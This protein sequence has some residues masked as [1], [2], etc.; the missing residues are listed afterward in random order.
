MKI[1]KVAVFSTCLRFGGGER[2]GVNI[3]NSLAADPAMN[4]SLIVYDASKSD[5]KVD[6]RVTVRSLAEPLRIEGISAQGAAF[7]RKVRKVEQLVS[8][9]RYDYSISIMSSLNLITLFAKLKNCRKIITEHNVINKSNWLLEAITKFLKS[10]LYKRAYKIVAVSEGVKQGLLRSIGVLDIDVIYNPIELDTIALKKDEPLEHNFGDY[11]LGVGRLTEQKGFDLLVDSFAML[12]GTNLNLV[13][14][15]EGPDKEALLQQASNL[16]VRDRLFFPGFVNNP[17]K[18]MKNAACFV[19]SSRWEGFGLV[20]A[21]ALAS[22]AKVVSFDCESGP[23]EIL[24][25]GKCGALVPKNDTKALSK[26]ILKAIK[27]RY[28][29]PEDSLARFKAPIIAAKYCDLLH[30]A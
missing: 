6:D 5:F 25:N 30:E 4:V 10:R 18:Y 20:V 24:L 11:I 21:E 28:P 13:I 2:V 27:T 1:T 3:A 16:G 29:S 14:L 8:V 26:A 22:D 9:E 15:G 23:A 12:A 19:L 7:L 17:Y